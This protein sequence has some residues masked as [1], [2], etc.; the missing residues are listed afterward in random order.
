MNGS[1][2]MKRKDLLE[3]ILLTV[4]LSNVIVQSLSA[5]SYVIR[6]DNVDIPLT[7]YL[8]LGQQESF[9]N[10]SGVIMVWK[11]NGKLK[12]IVFSVKESE[13]LFRIVRC[14]PKEEFERVL[15]KAETMKKED[16]V[17]MLEKFASERKTLARL[18]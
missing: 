13:T 16:F 6:V 10:S 14:M 1:P 2:G 18:K 11:E 7:S 17:T 5:Y 4:L 8:Q 9:K 3:T 12:H 15:K